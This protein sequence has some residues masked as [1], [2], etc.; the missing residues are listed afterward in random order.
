MRDVIIRRMEVQTM[1]GPDV[2]KKGSRNHVS[3]KDPER[4]IKKILRLLCWARL[5]EY[6]DKFTLVKCDRD[7]CFIGTAGRHETCGFDTKTPLKFNTTTCQ[8]RTS[9]AGGTAKRIGTAKK[10]LATN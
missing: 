10:I 4:V 5:L 3:W 1:G 7:C 8:E 6:F 9:S 2:P